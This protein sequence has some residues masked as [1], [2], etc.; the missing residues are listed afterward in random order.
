MFFGCQINILNN[1]G[2]LIASFSS[3]LGLMSD[4]SYLSPA[5]AL[6]YIAP[7]G[8]ATWATAQKEGTAQLS[9]FFLRFFLVF[10]DFFRWFRFGGF[11][12]VCLFYLFGFPEFFVI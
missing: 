5:G 10:A 9:R 2:R 6:E 8:G 12:M 11:F 7:V 3:V 1:F 4:K